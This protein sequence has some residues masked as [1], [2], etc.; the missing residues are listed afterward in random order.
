MPPPRPAGRC[1]DR[2]PRPAARR[3]FCAARPRQGSC[4]SWSRPVRPENRMPHIRP[5]ARG[6]LYEVVA[7]AAGCGPMP[8]F[9]RPATPRTRIEP[10]RGSI[11]SCSRGQG[12]GPRS[13][14]GTRHDSRLAG[15]GRARGDPT[16]G[17]ATPASSAPAQG[18]AGAARSHAAR[19]R[20]CRATCRLS[21]LCAG[22]DVPSSGPK[23]R[24]PAGKPCGMP[25]RGAPATGKHGA[26][27]GRRPRASPCGP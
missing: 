14:S 25:M 3:A 26:A 22:A 2:P 5:G 12:S 4:W 16:G 10:A 19:G 20:F 6:F 18:W 1:R 24:A 15:M 11:R 21:A 8:Q 17:A 7:G 9:R 23:A 13:C 27:S